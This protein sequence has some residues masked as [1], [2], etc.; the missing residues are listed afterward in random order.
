M[1]QSLNIP[2]RSSFKRTFAG[3]EADK[4]ERSS[5]E[6]HVQRDTRKMKAAGLFDSLD[7]SRRSLHSQG[8]ALSPEPEDSAE[9]IG[10]RECIVS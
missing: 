10:E 4:D 8:K 9:R 3:I 1:S 5:P 6:L 7:Q 2:E